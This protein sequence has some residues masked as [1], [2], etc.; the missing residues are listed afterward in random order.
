MKVSE[1]V[2]KAYCLLADVVTGKVKVADKVVIREVEGVVKVWDIEG[3]VIRIGEDGV[4]EI[5]G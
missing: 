2:R 4:V 1:E 3:R 5:E